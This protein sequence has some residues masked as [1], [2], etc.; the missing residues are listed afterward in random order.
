VTT[1]DEYFRKENWPS[2]GLMKIDV[3]GSE[4]SVLQGMRGLSVHSPSLSL[5]IEF[6]PTNLVAAGVQAHEFFEALRGNGFTRFF[7]ISDVPEPVS[8]PGDILALLEKAGP[9]FLNLLCT[10]TDQLFP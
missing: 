8:I 7:V 6:H 3:E 1:L 9:A 5:I 10:K 4:Y 2:V